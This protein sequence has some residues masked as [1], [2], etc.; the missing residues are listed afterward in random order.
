MNNRNN[1]T[2]YLSD[3]TCEWIT[4]WADSS[5]DDVFSIREEAVDSVYK[6]NNEWLNFFFFIGFSVL[7]TFWGC[8]ENR[9]EITCLISRFLFPFFLKEFPDLFDND[10][11]YFFI[12]E[13]GEKNFIELNEYFT[14]IMEAI[15][16]K[17]LLD[18]LH[19]A[20]KKE[21]SSEA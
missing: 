20:A 21:A 15:K 12:K 13:K 5:K 14:K 1:S 4:A 18:K 10:D 17:I 3:K 6:K 9:H 2:I 19:N 8:I 11:S 7:K 16:D